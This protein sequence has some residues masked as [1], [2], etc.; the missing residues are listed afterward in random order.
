MAYN[1]LS[2]LKGDAE[3]WV[4]KVRICRLWDSVS[5]KDNTLLSMD[6]VLSDEKG[7][8]MHAAVRK[9]LVPRFKR[10]LT[11]GLVYTLRNVK[12]TTNIYPYRPVASNLRLLFLATTGV[13]ALGEAEAVACIPKYGF[14]F[15]NQA[16]LRSRAD[17]VNTL[18]D[19][20]GCFCG[21]GE[22]EVVG[23]GHRKRDIRIFT[24]YSVTS[25]VTL[26][27]KLGELFDPTLYT[28]QDDGPYVIVVSS[29]T[30]KTYQGA[31]T[32]AT[33]SGSRVLLTRML[34]M[35]PL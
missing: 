17:D 24:D 18:S 32:F 3:N 12:V 23:A 4:I 14:Q 1:Y 13:E 26:W 7:N 6:M 16:A 33:T 35:S 10:L 25:T 21:F 19:I 20:V 27:G 15:V 5:T 28:L 30:V 8:L 2:D 31:L 29:V 34:I 9:H 22:I 11:E